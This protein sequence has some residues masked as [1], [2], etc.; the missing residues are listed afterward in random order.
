MKERFLN[1]ILFLFSLL[2]IAAGVILMFFTQLDFLN[3]VMTQIDVFFNNMK[4]TSF[5]LAF[6]GTILFSWGIFFFLMTIM[7]VMEI[8]TTTL[9]PFMFWIYTFWCAAACGVSYLHGF[10]FNLILISIIYAILFI[11]FFLSLFMRSKDK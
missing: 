10:F 2:F 11:P 1:I 4:F 6:L 7:A 3:L 9:Y 8:K 5:F